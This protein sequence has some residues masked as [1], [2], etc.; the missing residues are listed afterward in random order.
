MTEGGLTDRSPREGDVVVPRAAAV[1]G[2]R[3]PWPV[4]VLSVDEQGAQVF[5]QHVDGDEAIEARTFEELSEAFEIVPGLEEEL[6]TLD[7]KGA[8]LAEANTASLLARFRARLLAARIDCFGRTHP[9]LHHL[10]IQ[11]LPHQ[12]ATASR[13]LEKPNDQR[14]CLLLADEIGLGKTV[15]AGLIARLLLDLGELQRLIVL[16]PAPLVRQW[17]VELKQLFDLEAEVRELEYAAA[18]NAVISIDTLKKAEDADWERLFTMPCDTVFIDECH[19]IR[20]GSLRYRC[21]E[22]LLAHREIQNLILLSAT[23]FSGTGRDFLGLVTLLRAAPQKPI[24]MRLENLS[25]EQSLRRLEKLVESE[26]PELMVRHRRRDVRDEKGRPVFPEITVVRHKITLSRAERRVRSGLDGYIAGCRTKGSARPFNESTAHALH[27]A[28]ASSFHVLR[29]DLQRRLDALQASPPSAARERETLALEKLIDRWPSRDSKLEALLGIIGREE[30]VWSRARRRDGARSE[31]TPPLKFVI[32]TNRLAT[33]AYLV[34]KLNERPNPNLGQTDPRLPSPPAPAVAVALGRD[35]DEQSD[36]LDAFAGPARFLVCVR[37]GSRGLNLQQATVLINYDLPWNPAELE[38]RIGRINRMGQSQPTK[39]INFQCEGTINERVYDCLSREIRRQT[40]SLAGV[41]R[42]SRRPNEAAAEAD[43]NVTAI[44][45]SSKRVIDWLRDLVIEEQAAVPKAPAAVRREI[46]R[47]SATWN[48]LSRLV[49]RTGEFKL[50]QAGA[51][52]PLRAQQEIEATLERFFRLHVA[53]R[54]GA[55]IPMG[56]CS[57]IMLADGRDSMDA[58]A[59]LHGKTVT[60]SGQVAALDRNVE[61]LGIAHALLPAVIR[62]TAAYSFGGRTIDLRAALAAWRA[63]RGVVVYYLVSLP[64]PARPGA[65]RPT[66]LDGVVV[67]DDG[68]AAPHGLADA[69][70]CLPEKTLRIATARRRG[71]PV[72]ATFE[73][74]RRLREEADAAMSRRLRSA[75]EDPAAEEQA[76]TFQPIALCRF[77]NR[78][79]LGGRIRRLRQR[80]FGQ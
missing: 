68:R 21:V 19:E 42:R 11:P 36:A 20:F 2:G 72:T 8:G 45:G 77:E 44:L 5:L 24:A 16:C 78:P 41:S 70:V 34:Q 48:A 26:L 1:R 9:H 50:D 31:P 61:Y 30:K 65:M 79:G 52:A 47:A 12:A 14:R 74:L 40:Q 49:R 56:R 60:F 15:T 46:E 57:R 63:S 69:L 23:P 73:D 37:L 10:A 64:D 53:I 13:F 17:S 4:R 35:L 38:Q 58:L 32:F 43:E 33:Q 55:W 51:L 75:A 80:F 27:A 7:L 6:A 3:T 28:L 62:E 18:G 66:R 29:R 54:G 67:T 25:E 71:G 22:R 39:V 59:A 76:P